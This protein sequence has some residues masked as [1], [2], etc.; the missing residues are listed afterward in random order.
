MN[1]FKPMESNNVGD[2]LLFFKNMLLNTMQIQFVIPGNFSKVP[3]SRFVFVN[4]CTEVNVPI[5]TRHVW[6][7]NSRVLHPE[8]LQSRQ[9]MNKIVRCPDN[10]QLMPE[11]E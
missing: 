5:S 10:I 1:S 6:S 11:S 4:H 7:N 3:E 8:C 9:M 2:I